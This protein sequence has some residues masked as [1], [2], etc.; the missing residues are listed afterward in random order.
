MV[1]VSEEEKER[2]K[3]KRQ[4]YKATRES[5]KSKAV[6]KAVGKKR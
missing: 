6:G 1:Q 5:L 2:L 3:T 4:A